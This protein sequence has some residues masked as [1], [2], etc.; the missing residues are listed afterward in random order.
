MGRGN[1]GTI[2]GVT[3]DFHFQGLQKRI[4]PLSMI[5]RPEV[6]R[7]LNLTIKEENLNQTLAYVKDTRK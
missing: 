3:E 7:N 5:C 1:T 4:G 2:I 6:F